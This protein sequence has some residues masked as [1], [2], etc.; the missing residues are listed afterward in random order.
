MFLLLL[1]MFVGVKNLLKHHSFTVV[2]LILT[3]TTATP[4]E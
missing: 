1:Q 4:M 2:C 3:D